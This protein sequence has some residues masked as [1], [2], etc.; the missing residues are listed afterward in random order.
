MSIVEREAAAKA[1]AGEVTIGPQGEVITPL[2]PPV[3]TFGPQNEPIV[4]EN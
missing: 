1:P 2:P 3:I 4:E